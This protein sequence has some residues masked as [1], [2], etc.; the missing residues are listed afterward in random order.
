MTQ[1]ADY[2]RDTF[3]VAQEVGANARAAVFSNAIHGPLFIERVLVRFRAG[4]QD[5]FRV[6]PI[7]TTD[8]QAA[9]PETGRYKIEGGEV[10]IGGR[11]GGKKYVTGDDSLV[12]IGVY[13]WFD[14][15]RFLA[16]E[17]DNQGPGNQWL[18]V[19]WEVW[20]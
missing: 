1:E 16:V 9:Q 12:E 15:G 3:I 6:T 17:A 13:R 2:R 8:N 14:P 19:L 18:D 7:V 20:T 10:L 5:N 4:A 11:V